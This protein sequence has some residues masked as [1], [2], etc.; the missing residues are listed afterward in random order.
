MRKS[1]ALALSMAAIGAT[2]LTSAAMTGPVMAATTTRVADT[3]GGGD[4]D[5]TMTFT[6]TVGALTMTAPTT[7][8]LGAGGPGT[9]ISGAL[10]PVAVTD[11]RALLTATWTA[12]VSSSDF[13]TGGGTP[14]ETIPATDVA[15]DPG[16]ITTTGTITATGTPVTLS[17][18]AQP[19]VTGSA[20]VGD[21]SASWN[22]ALA[23]AVP[24]S[25]VGGAYTATLTQSVS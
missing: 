18:A 5:T 12:T 2:M 6:V 19:T 9:T 1:I 15:Y 11:A 4:P 10:G 21:N 22:P 7:V 8:D 3:P 24:S 17:N 20:G 13:T 14:A 23:V 25:A 16:T